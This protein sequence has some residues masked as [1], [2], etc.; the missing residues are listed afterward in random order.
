MLAANSWRVTAGA[1]TAN[2]GLMAHIIAAER[3]RSDLIARLSGS[4]AARFE[5][6]CAGCELPDPVVATLIGVTVPEMW[7]IRT[8]GPIPPAALPRINAFLEGRS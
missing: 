2:P 6:A 8:G 7:D 4:T 5:R 3:I 1:G